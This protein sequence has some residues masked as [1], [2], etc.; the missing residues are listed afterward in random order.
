MIGM[1]SAVC[2]ALT[3]MWPGTGKQCVCACVC[4]R[5]FVF[6]GGCFYACLFVSNGISVSEAK[7][8]ND[9]I[10]DFECWIKR[11]G[12]AGKAR[13]GK[14][15]YKAQLVHKAIQSAL[16]LYKIKGK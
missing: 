11:Q 1:R 9:Q 15:I 7:F 6:V 16:Q 8:P 12:K 14:F 2:S 13:Q 4:A 3:V 10:V 5:A